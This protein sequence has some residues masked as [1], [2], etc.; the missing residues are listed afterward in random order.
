MI[1][2][3]KT[4]LILLK[5][6]RKGIL[7]FLLFFTLYANSQKISVKV[8]YDSNFQEKRK[9]N[10][11]E[12]EL[13]SYADLHVQ[14]LV[15]ENY[16]EAKFDSLLY[17]SE[18]TVNLYFNK[19]C[20]WK[21]NF[22]IA[23]IDSFKHILENCTIANNFA[24]FDKCTNSNLMI[25]QKTG[26]IF[27]KFEYK[28]TFNIDTSYSVNA[29]FSNLDYIKINKIK[30]KSKKDVVKEKILARYLFLIPNYAFNL[31]EWQKANYKIENSKFFNQVK[32]PDFELTEKGAILY[33]YLKSQKKSNAS[34]MLGFQKLKDE[35]SFLGEAEIKLENVFLALETIN[36]DWSA[37]SQQQR[38]LN[39]NALFPYLLASPLGINLGVNLWQEDSSLITLKSENSLF[40]SLP[41]GIGISLET[42]FYNSLYQN[43]TN[44]KN[45]Y[46]LFGI[47]M[48]WNK[49]LNQSMHNMLRLR[50][51]SSDFYASSQARSKMYGENVFYYKSKDKWLFSTKFA[52]SYLNDDKAKR[53]EFSPLGGLKSFVGISENSI[54]AKNYLS[55]RLEFKNEIKTGPISILDYLYYTDNGLDYSSLLS[56]GAG[57]E[58]KQKNISIQLLNA[59]LLTKNT[60]NFSDSKLHLKFIS[61]F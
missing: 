25:L 59:Y 46:N 39:F 13:F 32:E 50:V 24:E 7:F 51:L 22:Y 60:L 28:W 37:N 45:T 2:Y 3:S 14:N 57:L 41:Q 9:L 18:N 36:L 17:K 1:L 44:E 49:I 30:I 47:G 10:F 31:H 55:G 58:I 23:G 35:I 20:Y 4:A 53:N 29:N 26:Y 38:K 34:G 21:S 40:Y 19:G 8:Y 16:L 12:S 43:D 61:Y 6:V 5:L 33:F 54:W 15:A 42:Y 52:F 56:F 27:A 48:S 11:S